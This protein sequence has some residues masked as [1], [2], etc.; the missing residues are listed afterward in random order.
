MKRAISLPGLLIGLVAGLVAGLVL[1]H[2]IGW[3]LF[4]LAVVVML[5][6]VRMQRG[7]KI[8]KLAKA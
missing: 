7:R 3:L 2:F 6:V 4:G 8:R 5:A 1:S